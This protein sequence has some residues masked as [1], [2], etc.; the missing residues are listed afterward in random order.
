MIMSILQISRKSNQTFLQKN[1][2]FFSKKF[3]ELKNSIIF[4]AELEN[5]KSNSRVRCGD[6]FV[7]T[8]IIRHSIRLLNLRIVATRLY[9]TCQTPV[10][11]FFYL[12]VNQIFNSKMTSPIKNASKAKDSSLAATAHASG[13]ITAQNK[14]AVGRK[15]PKSSIHYYSVSLRTSGKF[16]EDFKHGLY[17]SRIIRAVSKEEAVGYLCDFVKLKFPKHSILAEE[18]VCDRY[19]LRECLTPKAQKP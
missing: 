14:G 11:Q 16:A 2:T 1:I 19:I 10:Q 6:V 3:A 15:R 7:S 18:I 12:I 9:W 4:A 8:D 17:I 13:K 5:D